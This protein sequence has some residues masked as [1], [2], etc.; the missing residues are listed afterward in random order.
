[1]DL[2]GVLDSEENWQCESFSSKS[3]RLSLLLSTF[4]KFT[5]EKLVLIEV[6]DRGRVASYRNFRSDHKANYAVIDERVTFN[7][8]G[9]LI[10]IRQ[11]KTP[12]EKIEESEGIPDFYSPEE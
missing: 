10:L 2:A 1:M 6:T 3:G 5:L 8:E 12:A 9:Q 11:R 7:H 4:K